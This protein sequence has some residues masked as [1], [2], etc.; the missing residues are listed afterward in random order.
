MAGEEGHEYSRLVRPQPTCRGPRIGRGLIST[1]WLSRPLPS[2]TAW[3]FS[4]T[5]SIL[6]TWRWPNPRWN[7]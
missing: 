1:S 4:R 2:A 7:S 6:C 5:S 3:P